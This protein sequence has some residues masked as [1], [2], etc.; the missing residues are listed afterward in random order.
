MGLNFIECEENS[1]GEVR[2][3]SPEDTIE[4]DACSACALTHR[5]LWRT[6]LRAA[7]PEGSNRSSSQR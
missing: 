7:L 3:R 2:V 5:A 1:E 4:W 6:D